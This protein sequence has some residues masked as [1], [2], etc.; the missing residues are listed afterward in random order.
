M[1]TAFKA[2]SDPTRREILWL[3]RRGGAMPTD[4]GAWIHIGE[5]GVVTAH[6]GKVEVGQGARTELTQVVA[7][8]L[9]LPPV[10]VRMVLS[11][12]DLVPF[13]AGTFGSG[14]TPRMV[15]QLRRAA[16]AAREALL[17]L[18]AEQIKCERGALVLADGRVTHAPT[19]QSLTFGQLTK[20]QKLAKTIA[21]EI[22]TTP[23]DQWRVQGKSLRK[24]NAKEIV[25][26]KHKYATD[27][28][29]P[30]MRFGA[31]LRG[32]LGATLSSLDTKPAEAMPG[33]T[34]V[35]DGDFVGVVAPTE[36]EAR[37]AVAAMRAEWNRVT[38]PSHR[39]LFAHLKATGQPSQPNTA[40]AASLAQSDH[41]LAHTFNIA[42]IAHAPLEPRAAV[43]WSGEKLTVWTGTQRPFGVKGDLANALRIPPERVRVIVP[44]TGSGYGGKH[45]VDTATEAARLAKAVG[46][47]VKVVWTREEEFT[48][49][50]FRPGGVIDVAA[51]VTNGTL[52]AWDFHNYNSGGSSIRSLYDVPNQVAQFHGSRSP[53]RQG[54]YRAL[55]ATANHFAREVMMD[56]CAHAAKLDPLA[57]RLK[58]LKDERMPA[59]APSLR[60]ISG[61]I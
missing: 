22:Q 9:R 50:Y 19:K 61:S 10:A 57:F 49:A 36:H 53:L 38:M 51:G 4:V 26:G 55:A 6:S 17:D 16:A 45:T 7:E 34:V 15:P 40:V 12:T 37:Q 58:N 32:P 20:G 46:K 11:D 1:S 5:D 8:E 56:E 43:E 60:S 24:V 25:T 42:Y 28:Q 41:K 54:S 48:Y 47:P 23:I 44:D 52:V 31:V 13:D 14:T 33:V 59:R 27:V 3:L 30:G 18:A 29:R 21:G 39:E 35:R 2:L